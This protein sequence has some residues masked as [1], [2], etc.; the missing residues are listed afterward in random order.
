MEREIAAVLFLAFSAAATAYDLRERRIPNILNYAFLLA[1]AGLAYWSG[2]GLGYAAFV[3]ASFC[4]AYLVYRL[5]AWA[6]G[7]AK[8]FTAL[9]AFLPLL[10]INVG[11]PAMFFSFIWAFIASAAVLVP[12]AAIIYWEKLASARKQVADAAVSSVVPSVAGALGATGTVFILSRALSAWGASPLG[13][14]AILLLF[15]ALRVPLWLGAGLAAIAAVSAPQQALGLFAFS[16]AAFFL[17]KFSRAAY[18]IISARVFTTK[19]RAADLREGMIPAETVCAKAGK[20][21]FWK[22]TAA[23]IA[24]GLLAGKPLVPEGR[25]VADSSK[26]AGL[27]KKQIAELKR[28]GVKYL[29]IRE[30]MPFAPILTVGEAAFAVVVWLAAS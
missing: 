11:D 14:A 2:Y 26:A 28:L 4:F 21:V 25:V 3:A 12:V 30:S 1:A 16:L 19:T 7:D 10:G 17:A 27:S 20:P 5:G 9:T 22:P 18:P 15:Y 29:Q 24:A 13:A 6:G 23:G 8:F